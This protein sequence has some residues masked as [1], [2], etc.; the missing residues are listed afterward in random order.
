MRSET[1]RYGCCFD[2]FVAWL[3]LCGVVLILNLAA[4]SLVANERAREIH[5]SRCR[6]MGAKWL[7]NKMRG[8][9]Q[10]TRTHVKC[11]DG[12][13]YKCE[14]HQVRGRARNAWA[15]VQ[16]HGPHWMRGRQLRGAWVGRTVHAFPSHLPRKPRFRP[17]GPRWAAIAR[18]V[19]S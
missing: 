19:K 12:L 7:G 9:T 17:R 4:I 16:L 5:G 15:A 13:R 18:H 8:P 1:H 6:C 14:G 11:A 3:I 2:I 10:S